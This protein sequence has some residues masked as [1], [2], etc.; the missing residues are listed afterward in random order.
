MPRSRSSFI[1]ACNARGTTAPYV[2]TVRS[3]PGLTIF[4]LPKGMVKS[5]PGYWARPKVSR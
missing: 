2:T 4:A 1:A 3:F 5:G